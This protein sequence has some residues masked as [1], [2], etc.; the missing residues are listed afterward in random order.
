MPKLNFFNNVS[1]NLTCFGKPIG[2]ARNRAFLLLG[3]RTSAAREM[4]PCGMA[5]DPKRRLVVRSNRAG[6]ALAY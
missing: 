5:G 2:K 6:I 3:S 1:L 4:Q